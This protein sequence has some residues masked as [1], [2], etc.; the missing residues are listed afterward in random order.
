[1]VRI[2]FFSLVVG[3]G[4]PKTRR[5]AG[6]AALSKNMI[7][8]VYTDRTKCEVWT[9]FLTGLYS[10]FLSNKRIFKGISYKPDIF[11]KPIFN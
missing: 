7:R 8:V 6:S 9:S 2:L 5:K 3:G 10:I 1:M 4:G 11:I